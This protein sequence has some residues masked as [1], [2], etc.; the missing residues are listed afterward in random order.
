MC[1]PAALDAVHGNADWRVFLGAAGTTLLAGSILIAANR[2]S[3][4]RLSIRQVILLTIAGWL[5]VS[6]AAA[7]P[8]A[9]S[10]LHLSIADAVFEAVSG[11]TTTGSTVIRGLGN[12]APGLLL[13]RALLQWLGGLGFLA[14][15]I[16]VLPALDIGG[17][18]IFRLQTIGLD[19]LAVPRVAKTVV[20]LAVVYVFLTAVLTLLLWSAG[21]SR[22]PSLLHAMTT[23][24]CGG[25]STSDGSIGSWHSPAI[26]WIVLAGML[27]GG[28]PFLTY[29]EFGRWRWRAVFGNSQV[30]WYLA[31]FLAA[32]ASLS[33]WLLLTKGVKPLPSIRHGAF[34][35]AS[36]M[37]GTGFATLD[38]G[39]W[40]GFGVAVLF[41]L[42][43][44]GG[45]AGSTAGGI[46]VFR[47]QILVANARLQLA[48]LV[49]PH[50]VLLPEYDRKPVTDLIRE[51]VLGFL[52]VYAMSFAVLSMALGMLG[53]SF[54]AA[55][56]TAASALANLGPGLAPAVGPLAG[57]AA[58]PDAAK[59][60]L[61]AAML[62]GRLE[63]FVFL[64]LFSPTFWKH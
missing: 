19:D 34:I 29:L 33:L 12:V 49:R 20:R 59:W 35:A 10:G 17:M 48:R 36:V 56:S 46:K 54:V 28:A 22:F 51:S 26:D 14:M 13:W 1:L 61:A 6:L 55:I 21:M 60:L 25:F 50:A 8:F 9:F 58:L 2:G 38:Y 57:Y 4:G 44:V 31:I 43:F 53:L 5:A 64:A 30:R 63:M 52:F 37:T 3:H 11:V 32:A 24:S 18:R 27:L 39:Q 41:F 40:H 45:C 23:I 7:L 16:V 47:F 15:A 62:F 42:T